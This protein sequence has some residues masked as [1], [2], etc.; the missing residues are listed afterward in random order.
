VESLPGSLQ[1]LVN[2]AELTQQQTARYIVNSEFNKAQLYFLDTSFIE[3]EQIGRQDRRAR[4]SADGTTAERICRAIGQFRLN[5][6]H[7][8]LFFE[9]GSNAEFK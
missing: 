1:C 9:D 2:L 6:K 5:A 7:L 8:Q 3:F 4:A